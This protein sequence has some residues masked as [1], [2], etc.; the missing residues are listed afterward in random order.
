MEAVVTVDCSPNWNYANGAGIVDVG[1][2][3]E[4][5]VWCVNY[6]DDIFRLNPDGVTWTLIDGKLVH[7][8]VGPDGNAW[9][10]NSAG[11]I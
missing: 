8:D 5:S 3:S 1:V 6:N 4:G 2:G 7:I 11:N 10:V 9:G